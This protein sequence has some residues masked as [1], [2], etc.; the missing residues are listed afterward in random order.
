MRR[1]KTQYALI[2][3]KDPTH[4]ILSN[5]YVYSN[6]KWATW[7]DYEFITNLSPI[8]LIWCC[9]QPYP[10]QCL[11]SICSHVLNYSTCKCANWVLQ[12][13][14]KPSLVPKGDVCYLKNN[15]CYTYSNSILVALPHTY[16]IHF[17]WAFLKFFHTSI[18]YKTSSIILYLF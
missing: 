13:P 16:V 18:K 5:S 12:A 1:S 2:K 6:S 11:P 17:T 4:H 3:H 9:Y 15:C 8:L 14:L 7:V 10:D